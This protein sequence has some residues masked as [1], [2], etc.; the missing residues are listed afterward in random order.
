MVRYITVLICQFCQY[1][2]YIYII[3]A[4]LFDTFTLDFGISTPP[5]PKQLKSI[6]FFSLTGNQAT[7]LLSGILLRNN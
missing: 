1:Y 5:F 2:I 3:I 6:Q 7:T 4:K